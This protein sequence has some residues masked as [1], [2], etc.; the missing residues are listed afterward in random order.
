MCVHTRYVVFGTNASTKHIKDVRDRGNCGLT[1][2]NRVPLHH[3][4][5]YKYAW[6]LWREFGSAAKKRRPSFL[7]GIL[8]ISKF[9]LVTRASVLQ[10]SQQW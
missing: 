1:D 6:H 10:P 8:W 2:I 9:E 3:L 4:N 7:L 5:T